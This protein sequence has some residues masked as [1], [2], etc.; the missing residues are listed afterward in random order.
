MTKVGV[1]ANLSLFNIAE[2]GLWSE[3]LSWR[4]LET[5][6]FTDTQNSGFHMENHRLCTVFSLFSTQITRTTVRTGRWQ[7]PLS[8]IAHF[9]L[10]N[11]K[12]SQRA[13]DL[14]TPQHT[15][16]ADNCGGSMFLM[17]AHKPG[18]QSSPKTV[19]PWTARPR[20]RAFFD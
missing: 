2:S 19:W 8:K 20:A 15:H 12:A 7:R 18:V 1:L 13:I 16:L 6:Q 3:E 5:A 17:F 9:A 10:Q 4:N 14:T 11:I